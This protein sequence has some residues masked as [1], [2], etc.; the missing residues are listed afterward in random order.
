[1]ATA[2]LCGLW[3]LNALNAKRS[4][5][6]KVVDALPC[7]LQ[8]IWLSYRLGAFHGHDIAAGFFVGHFETFLW[9]FHLLYKLCIGME[10]KHRSRSGIRK[11]AEES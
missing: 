1:M 8:W 9:R 2:R 3:L 10:W 4:L 7:I 6:G 11:V 5:R